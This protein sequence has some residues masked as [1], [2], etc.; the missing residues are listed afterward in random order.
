[1][2]EGREQTRK[3]RSARCN[4]TSYDY[5]TSISER[6]EPPEKYFKLRDAITRVTG[7]QARPVPSVDKAVTYPIQPARE[8][9]SLW[10]N[11]PKPILSPRLMTMEELGQ[12]YGY[13]LYTTHLDAAQ[14]GSL[15]L[16][17]LHD[18]ARIYLDHAL[19]GILN[20]RL[21]QGFARHS[22]VFQEP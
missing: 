8:S 17:G 16:D 18:Y 19:A 6:G 11:L 13:I 12:S 10:A 15:V 3:R 4:V 5:D 20:R 14:S 21:N 1:M 22:L 7:I 2:D 9:V